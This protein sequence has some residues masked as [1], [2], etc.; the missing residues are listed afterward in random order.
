MVIDTSA[1]M[2]TT[3]VETTGEVL[4]AGFGSA[5]LLLAEALLLM[6]DP[7][8]SPALAVKMNVKV[9]E[10]PAARV[11]AVS[12]IVPVPPAAGV[13]LLKPAG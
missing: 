4:L 12:V 13:V 5:V 7:A 9:A 10:A 3:V 1:D 8:R 2:P 6:V 11:A